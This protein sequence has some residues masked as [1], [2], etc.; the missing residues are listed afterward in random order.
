MPD[1]KPPDERPKPPEWWKGG[2][3]CWMGLIRDMAEV[4]E[5][6][7]QSAAEAHARGMRALVDRLV[8]EWGVCC[9]TCQDKLDAEA[10]A[11]AVMDGGKP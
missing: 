10:V 5:C 6:S 4:V 11:K 3:W 8:A 7:E 2:N 1:E 9:A